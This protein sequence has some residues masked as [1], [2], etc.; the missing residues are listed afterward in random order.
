MV[1]EFSSEN[2][3]ARD[4][5]RFL[6]S[7]CWSITERVDV[8]YL[9]SWSVLHVKRIVLQLQKQSSYARQQISLRQ[10]GLK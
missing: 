7:G 9:V 10:R 1:K 2:T 8:V 3:D 4:D 5:T 6:G